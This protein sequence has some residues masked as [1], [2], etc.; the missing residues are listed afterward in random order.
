ME[1]A[2]RTDETKQTQQSTH[3]PGNTQQY[4]HPGGGVGVAEGVGGERGDGE[5][6]GNGNKGNTEKR[7]AAW[8]FNCFSPEKKV[9]KP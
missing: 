6:K 9:E 2:R 5:D 3:R 4:T 8:F 1:G 7:N